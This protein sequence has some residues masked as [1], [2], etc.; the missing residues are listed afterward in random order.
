[1]RPEPPPN[2]D[3]LFLMKIE[4]GV[5]LVGNVSAWQAL[6]SEPS[7]FY[8]VVPAIR[9]DDAKKLAGLI[10]LRVKFASYQMDGNEVSR[11]RYE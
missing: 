6:A 5:D 7:V 4:T 11:I 1:M 9:L 10:N 3:I 8:L 2:S